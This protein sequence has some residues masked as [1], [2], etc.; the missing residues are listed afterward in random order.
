LDISFGRIY[1]LYL[2]W[3]NADAYYHT[4]FVHGVLLA[5]FINFLIGILYYFTGYQLF[6]FSL[7]PVG[8]F[9]AIVI[10][11]VVFYF[12]RNKSYYVESTKWLSNRFTKDDWITIGL[13]IILFSTW[14][15][16]P[17][18]YKWGTNIH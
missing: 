9:L 7:F 11:F 4:A 3:G 18:V 13:N 6:R 1:K 12:Y 10:G 17:I 8:V 5:S 16:S 14:F 2:K 15:I